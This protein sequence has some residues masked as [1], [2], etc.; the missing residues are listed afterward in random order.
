MKFISYNLSYFFRSNI[1]QARLTWKSMYEHK[2]SIRV[3]LGIKID[4][5]KFS[6]NRCKKNTFH[7]PLSSHLI[8]AKLQRLE[9][10]IDLYFYTANL[11]ES[12]IS[13]SELYDI[14]DSK[15]NKKISLKISDCF[16][17]FLLEG[18]KTNSWSYNTLR[19]LQFLPKLIE[20]FRPGCYVTDINSDFVNDFVYFLQHHRYSKAEIKGNHSGYTNN[21]IR[22]HIRRLK[23]FCRW[24]IRNGLINS[25][26]HEI[27]SAK[28]K[29]V[30]NPIIYLTR[31]EI[32][33]ISALNLGPGSTIDKARDIFLFC[34]YTSLRIG[35][36]RRL[37]YTAIDNNVIH[38]VAQKIEKI[39]SIEL[40][41]G[42][43]RII[44][45]Y[46]HSCSDKVL[47]ELS[48]PLLNNMIK[49]IGKLA[50]IDNP[51]KV[52]KYYGYERVETIVPKYE[53]LS[54]HCGRKTF[55]VNALSAGIS[56][57][58]V[59]AWTGH[60]TY[61]AMQPYIDIASSAKRSAMSMLS[62][63]LGN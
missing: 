28:I 35:D 56:P 14:F 46:K 48:I 31:D 16:I 40:Q 10:K 52:V 50:G 37:D 41:E 49:K 36:A 39:L 33:R 4:P 12:N 61:S 3:S 17:A 25:N 24:C 43:K 53:L 58:V 32:K 15:L 47:P 11:H 63:Y 51:V 59:M 34:C 13:T 1:L 44:E 38:I 57:N 5:E 2:Q 18:E 19:L 26:L 21:T 42:A 9:D 22:A 55:I 45:K 62:N 6:G 60:S 20:F 27:F 8:N 7:G 23:W 29:V 54:S 30:D